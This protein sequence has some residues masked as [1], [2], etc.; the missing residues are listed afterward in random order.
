MLT[1]CWMKVFINQNLEWLL[2]KERTRKLQQILQKHLKN[3]RGKEL[4]KKKFDR[5]ACLLVFT[6]IFVGILIFSLLTASDNKKL[7]RTLNETFDFVKTRIESYE[8]YDTND[9]VKSLVRLMDKTT[10]LSRVIAQEGN[11]RAEMLDK[12]AKKNS[13]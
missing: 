1:E 7:N 2:K 8:I 4:Q 6:L 9:Q 12:Y 3:C 13:V 10:E 5:N 11:F